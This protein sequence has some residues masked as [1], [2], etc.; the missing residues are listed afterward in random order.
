MLIV[1]R[2]GRPPLLAQTAKALVIGL[3][4]EGGDLSYEGDA[5]V[6]AQITASY[7]VAS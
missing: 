4:S 5:D 6:V 7:G 2:R 1:W 3:L